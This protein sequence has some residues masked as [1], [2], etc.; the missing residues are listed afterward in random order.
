MPSSAARSPIAMGLYNRMR[1]AAGHRGWWPA[2][3]SA[4]DRGRDEIIIGAV[5]TQNTSWKNVE[6]A[7]ESLRAA[8]LL[9]LARLAAMEP[10]QIAPHIRAAG[11]FNVKARRLHSVA[12]FF[13]PGGKPRFTQLARLGDD[14]LRAQLLAVHGVGRETADSILLYA[15]GRLSFVVDAY[16]LRIG[17]RHGLFPPGA[18]YEQAR[19]WF[20]TRLPHDAALFNDYHAQL[21]RIGNLYCKPRPRCAACPLARRDCTASREAWA[22]IRERLA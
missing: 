2:D 15:L 9:S 13:A 5:L 1:A 22:A 18:D 10:D 16:T 7:I 17:V 4:P 19:A 8:G 11:Y 6:R 3:R 12:R 14:E 20:T 21:V